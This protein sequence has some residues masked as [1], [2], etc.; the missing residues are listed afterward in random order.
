MVVTSLLRFRTGFV[1]GISVEQYSLTPHDQQQPALI[2]RARTVRYPPAF[3]YQATHWT[4]GLQIMSLL[5]IIVC[6]MPGW[7]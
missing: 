2:H 7:F 6:G 3:N 4:L 5:Q 1:G